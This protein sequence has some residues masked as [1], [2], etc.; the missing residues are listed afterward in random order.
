[1]VQFSSTE[2]AAMPL[3]MVLQLQQFIWDP[4]AVPRDIRNQFL[5]NREHFACFQRVRET[6]MESWENEKCSGSTSRRRVFLQ[7]SRVLSNFLECFYNHKEDP[8][9]KRNK[10]N[11]LFQIR[12]CKISIFA[13]S[14]VYES[15]KRL[16]FK[17]HLANG[18]FLLFLYCFVVLRQLNFQT[19]NQKTRTSFI[20]LLQRMASFSQA[21]REYISYL[22]SSRSE[23]ALSKVNEQTN[24]K[25]IVVVL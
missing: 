16:A 25:K 24:K 9:R 7:L 8:E 23:N 4:V 11:S 13:P 1:M 15:Y 14:L 2:L 17:A 12:E 18:H 3:F 20:I 21:I 5:R 19:D 6:R 10:N 22:V